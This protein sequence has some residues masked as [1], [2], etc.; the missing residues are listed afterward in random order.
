MINDVSNNYV[1]PWKSWFDCFSV[2]SWIY[3][4]VISGKPAC[5]TKIK[6]WKG[7]C[8][9]LFMY[10]LGESKSINHHLRGRKALSLFNRVP[11]RTRRAL[12]LCKVY[13][14]IAPFWFS[15]D[16]RWTALTPFWLSADAIMHAHTYQ[17]TV[18]SIIMW[19]WP[20][21]YLIW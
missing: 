4:Y 18:N 10:R 11:L 5:T 21:Y 3:T 6:R 17:N 8:H 1:W 2:W 20:R 13:M 12:P 14:A 15:T 19:N 16:H 7:F 9:K